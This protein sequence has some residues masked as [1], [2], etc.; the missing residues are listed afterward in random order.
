MLSGSDFDMG[1]LHNILEN[2]LLGIIQSL[3][4]ADD[5]AFSVMG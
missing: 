3:T 2:L 5:P 1:T 4:L